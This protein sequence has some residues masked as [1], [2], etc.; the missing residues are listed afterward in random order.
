MDAQQFLISVAT[1]IVAAI[2]IWLWR[3]LARWLMVRLKA[4]TLAS[5]FGLLIRS[6]TVTTSASLLMAAL[7]LWGLGKAL[8]VGPESGAICF[9]TVILGLLV[10]Y[11]LSRLVKE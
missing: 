7:N 5:A 10:A 6:K 8:T 1:N 3:R 4:K 2:V 11:W 9:E